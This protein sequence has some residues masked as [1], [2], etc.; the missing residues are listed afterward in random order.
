MP[1][2]HTSLE[3]TT[4]YANGLGEEQRNIAARM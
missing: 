4:I 3:V 2:K 1:T